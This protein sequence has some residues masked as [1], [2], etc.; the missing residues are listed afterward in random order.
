MQQVSSARPP[1]H[2]LDV[3]PQRDAYGALTP[4]ALSDE[5]WRQA[6]ALLDAAVKSGKVPAPYIS[7]GKNEF[8]CLNLDTYDLLISRR[9][10]K[11]L[12]VQARWFWKNSRKGYTRGSKTYYL[13]Q[14]A[15]G[16]I[17]VTELQAATCVK[18]A[19]NATA[20]GQL[21]AHYLGKG[22][23]KCKAPAV[24]PGYKVVARTASGRL[25]SAFDGSEYKLGVWRSEMARE[26]HEGGFYYYEDAE[27]A[28]SATQRGRTF[29][30][31][32]SEGKMLVLCEVEVSG[33]QVRY[34]EG[35]RAA[36]RLRIVRELTQVEVTT[37]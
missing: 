28:V 17:T 29:S 27:E 16:R 20:L 9:K 12:V 26:D 1:Q 19:K 25:V 5:H 4:S 32:V 13:V 30:T 34:A 10:V 23:L 6:K 18:R 3:T 11:A 37:S 24:Y 2:H 14:K 33:R 35:K 21:V 31:Q 36:S 15:A 22:E 8:E 7:G